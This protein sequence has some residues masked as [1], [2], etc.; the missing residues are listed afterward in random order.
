MHRAWTAVLGLAVF[1]FTGCA[2]KSAYFGQIPKP[3]PVPLKDA[4][5]GFAAQGCL[6]NRPCREAEAVFSAIYG[7][8]YYPE[9][10]KLLVYVK[11]DGV[12]LTPVLM[13]NGRNTAYLHGAK[14][15]FV[16]VVAEN[17]L[18]LEARVTTLT[19]KWLNPFV[20]LVSAFGAATEKKEAEVQV[21]PPTPMRLNPIKSTG[22]ETFYYGATGF[23][24]ETDTVIRVSIRSVHEEV[25]V[26]QD[27][28][29]TFPAD[30]TKMTSAK[31]S[32]TSTTKST[33]PEQKVDGVTVNSEDTVT[34]SA[35]EASSSQDPPKSK[36]MRTET[37]ELTSTA[38]VPVTILQD[39]PQLQAESVQ[40]N[41]SNT[42]GSWAGV[43][44]GA[45]GVTGVF[46][47][48]VKLQDKEGKTLGRTAATH[49][50]GAIF[51]GKLY[52][53]RPMLRVRGEGRYRPSIALAIGTNLSPSS[54]FNDLVAGISFGHLLGRLGFV[55]G[56]EFAGARTDFSDKRQTGL[57]VGFDYSF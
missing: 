38:I 49:N 36:T 15:L 16:I 37:R 3:T 9:W 19:P 25:T 46:D 23:T 20:G 52:F 10:P 26:K 18:R 32:K 35:E 41:L 50:L 43:G 2:E 22:G 8:L 33:K 14:N 30:S 17:P 44:I 24:L 54:S 42:E 48:T 11:K 31:T 29:T 4:L 5:D 12:P 57:F 51:Y 39:E 27:T 13:S 55:S 56:V 6:V 28:V 45:G 1:V 34:V 21:S 40:A 7:D 47:K 53:R